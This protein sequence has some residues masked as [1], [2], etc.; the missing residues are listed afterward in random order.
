MTAL[1]W[2]KGN[3]WALLA[4]S[5]AAYA[6]ATLWPLV[7]VGTASFTLLVFTQYRCWTPRG[8]FGVANAITALRLAGVFTLAL[9][10]NAL[11]GPLVAGAALAILALDGLDGWAARRLGEASV[12]GEYLDKETDA[13]L[14][15]VVV[16]ITFLDGCAGTWLLIVGLLR[17]AF[18]LA[19]AAIAPPGRPERRS[20]RAA[21]VSIGMLA[22]LVLCFILP[23]ALSLPLVSVATVALVGS[24]VI[25]M[26]A[27]F[28]MPLPTGALRTP[29]LR[30][31]VVEGRDEARAFFDRIARSYHEQHGAA[32]RLLAYRLRLIRRLAGDLTGATVLDVACG[33]G[34][35]LLDLALV[36]GRGIGIDFSPAMIAAALERSASARLGANLEFRVDDAER[37][38]SIDDRSVDAVLCIGAL[39]HIADKAAVLRSVARVLRP[40]GRF[41]CLTSDAD[42]LWYRRLAP[43]LGVPT[44]H[45]SSDLRLNAEQLRELLHAAG[46][47]GIATRS[48]T[49]VPRGDVTPG[50]GL[51]LVA[52]D[53]IGRVTRI[54]GCRGGLLVSAHKHAP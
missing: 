4:A 37:L 45:L 29:R 43:W 36:V 14:L 18:V 35:H 40:A 26:W 3:A 30:T 21:V 27:W 15:L 10:H 5:T 39:E 28:E 12:F 20:R 53:L 24:F 9:A 33:P 17:Y 11:P 25:D 47:G 41:V 8:R 38:S 13:L 44:V 42:Y 50:L 46:F 54:P 52:L 1:A 31:T 7:L 16:F 51:L 22:A 34:D 32:S 19:A 49:F 48:W 2:S 6:A 23:P